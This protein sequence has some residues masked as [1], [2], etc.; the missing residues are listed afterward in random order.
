LIWRLSHRFDRAALPLADRHYNRQTPGSP[1]F[2]PPGRCLVLMAGTKA[3]WVTSWPFAEYTSHAWAGAWGNSLFRNEGGGLS[4]S[5][6]RQAVAA[7]RWKYGAP[8][9][10]GMVTFVDRAKVRSK[11]DPG[12]CYQCAG[13]RVVGKTAKRGF[14]AL[15]LL[16]DAMPEPEAPLGASLRLF[17][18]TT[19]ATPGSDAR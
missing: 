12:Y 3:L 16:P 17:S 9:A 1:Q 13:F 5:L 10:L 15:Q 2:A 4:S 18:P 14:V 11:R 8:P 19:A 6:I 7:T